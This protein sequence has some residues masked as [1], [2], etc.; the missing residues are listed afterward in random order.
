M[1]FLVVN[2]FHW[3][4]YHLVNY[5]LDNGNKVDGLDK[6]DT[7]KKDNLS[8][9]I[10]RNSQFTFVEEQALAN[11]ETAI[12]IGD[13]SLISNIS[14][15]RILLIGDSNYHSSSNN[16][17]QI[18][19]PILIGEWMPMTEDGC[20]YKDQFISF[21]SNRFLTEAVYIEDFLTA[22]LQW[23]ESSNLPS[24]ID[25]FARK[26]TNKESLKLENCLYIRDNVSIEDRLNKLKEHFRRYNK[27]YET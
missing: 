3:I 19:T 18:N 17:V 9:F 2:C 25:V 12:V 14:A 5:L 4:G 7:T 26:K 20:Y 15:S 21:E 11:Y 27:L 10:G 22:M 24:Q 23:V 8:M 16:I 1:S 13:T 6:L